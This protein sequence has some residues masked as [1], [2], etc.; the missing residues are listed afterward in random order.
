[1]GQKW[2]QHKSRAL[3]SLLL[4]YPV[5]IAHLESMASGST[6]ADGSRFC[7]YLKVLTSF[8]LVLHMLLFYVLLQ[9]LA[10]LFCILQGE[11]VDLMFAMAS[12]ESFPASTQSLES[13]HEDRE[14]VSELS[15]FLRD[16]QL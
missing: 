4:S 15:K 2:L 16:I 5:T 1:M 6:A 8:K 12:L 9:P 11:S 7:G 10:A 13:E 3:A 14:D